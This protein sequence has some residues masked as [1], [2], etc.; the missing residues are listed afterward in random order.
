MPT[1]RCAG[2][3]TPSIPTTGT[4]HLPTSGTPRLRLVGT[5]PLPTSGTPRYPIAPVVE[6]LERALAMQDGVVSRAQLRALGVS[7]DRI[8]TW[9]AHGWRRVVRGVYVNHSGE[10]TLRQRLWVAVLANWPAAV[11]HGSALPGLRLPGPS[12][13]IHVAVPSAR[14]HRPVEGVVMHEMLAFDARVNWTASPPHVRAP[15]ALLDVM[16]DRRLDDAGMVGLLCDAVRLDLVT[17][18]EVLRAMESRCKVRGRLWLEGVLLDLVHGTDSV[19]EHQFL[20]HVE[21]AHALPTPTRQRESIDAGTGRA[22]RR[23]AEWEE[24][25]VVLELDGWQ[26]HQGEKRAADLQRDLAAAAHEGLVTLRLSW[27]QVVGDACV[28]AAALAKVLQRRGW[29]GAMARC[30]RCP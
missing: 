12:G 13:V 14:K 21:R 5:A 15:H 19:L 27:R 20:Q 1:G 2:R 18:A 24:W 7:N 23:D 4:L 9:L 29:S 25:G 3:M 30:P 11:S 22:I 16:R 8:R 10:L 28:T 26:F 17:P 6:S